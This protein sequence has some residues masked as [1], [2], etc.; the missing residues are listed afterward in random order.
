MPKSCSVS[1]KRQERS[2]GYRNNLSNYPK[3]YKQSDWLQYH[4]LEGLKRDVRQTSKY[5]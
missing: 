3:R 5:L 1:E 2:N 4:R